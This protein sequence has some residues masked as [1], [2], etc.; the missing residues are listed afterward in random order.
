MAY[1]EAQRQ[2][3]IRELQGY[4]HSIS[5]TNSLPQI[6]PDSVYGEST[7]EAVRQFQQQNQLPPTGET[8]TATWNAV[9]QA[10]LQ[11]KQPQQMHVELFPAGITAY[12]PG[13][14]GSAVFLI[15]GLLQAIRAMFPEIPP[16]ES[17]GV[18]D[19]ATQHAVRQFQ[20]YTPLPPSGIVNTE[21]WNHLVAAVQ[22]ERF[23]SN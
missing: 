19:S 7:A 17:S 5:H 2:Q 1:T 14:K 10:Y 11:E 20:T 21:T 23:Q 13:D 22:T 12:A 9:V 16:V 18:Y 4:L 3:H 6:I 8:D 15:Q